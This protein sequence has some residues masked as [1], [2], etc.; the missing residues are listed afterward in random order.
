MPG[1]CEILTLSIFIIGKISL[2]EAVIKA[3]SKFFIS[4]RL[5]SLSI[6]GI[7]NFLAN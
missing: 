1:L 6:T 7:F 3:S 5:I 4:L 2:L